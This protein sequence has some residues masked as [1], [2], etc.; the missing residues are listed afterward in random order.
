MKPTLYLA[1]SIYLSASVA[2]AG[3]SYIPCGA[4]AVVSPPADG[5]Q[6]MIG[7]AGDFSYVGDRLAFY[8]GYGRGSSVHEDGAEYF[9]DWLTAGF[10]LRVGSF[11]GFLIYPTVLFT[12]G[13]SSQYYVYEGYF[14]KPDYHFGYSRTDV[15][16]TEHAFLFGPAF[17]RYGGSWPTLNLMFGVG[18]R[19]NKEEGILVKTSKIP[20]DKYTE[21]FVVDEWNY[22]MAV[23]MRLY[24]ML[25][26][27]G[28][29]G[30]GA[31]FEGTV[32]PRDE[33]FIDW[34]QE[35]FKKRVWTGRDVTAWIGPAVAF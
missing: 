27:F 16:A 23:G 17:G 13:K 4:F 26:I 5:V 24:A 7:W 15:E 12:C 1:V 32:A 29:V 35:L 22:D 10:G 14:R 6:S 20:D 9:R 30:L 3:G 31:A 28:P 2:G 11:A 25:P 34:D 18:W 19:Q 21:I 8:A 33:V